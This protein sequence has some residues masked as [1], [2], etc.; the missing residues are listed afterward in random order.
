MRELRKEEKTIIGLIKKSRGVDRVRAGIYARKSRDDETGMSLLTQI[1]ECKTFINKNEKYIQ[2]NEK[3]IYKEDDVTGMFIE[4][5]IELDNLLR[6]VE[7]GAIDVVIDIRTL[8]RCCAYVLNHNCEYY[9][10]PLFRAVW[11][12]CD[13]LYNEVWLPHKF[14]VRQ[15]TNNNLP[16]TSFT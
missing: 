1:D 8:S 5:R 9:H 14:Q 2:F 10:I 7:V 15:L 16:A 12:P 3:M 6:Q 4:E 13:V 11:A